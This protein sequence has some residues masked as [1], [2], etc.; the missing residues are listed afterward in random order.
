MNTSFTENL[1][2]FRKKSSSSWKVFE[3]IIN[4]FNHIMIGTAST[5][6]G[7]ASIW[8]SLSTF[9]LKTSAIV[10]AFLT[11]RFYTTNDIGTFWMAVIFR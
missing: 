6:L 11:K 4:T 2:N 3:L 10:I 1:T 7:T 8:H 5:A 9:S